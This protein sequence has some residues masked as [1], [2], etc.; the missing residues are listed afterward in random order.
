MTNVPTGREDT[1]KPPQDTETEAGGTH[2]QAK[3]P[4]EARNWQ[5]TTPC[6]SFQKERLPPEPQISDFQP[7]E[8]QGLPLFQASYSV[9][10][11]H[12]GSQASPEAS[13]LDGSGLNYSFHQNTQ[14]QSPRA[15]PIE[16]SSRICVPFQKT[17]H[18]EDSSNEIGPKVS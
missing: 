15:S 13:V 11:C 17:W 2:L 3:E 4:P 1:G 16:S 5:G 9:A 7:P 6:Q 10:L 12:R 14:M 18:T 8:A